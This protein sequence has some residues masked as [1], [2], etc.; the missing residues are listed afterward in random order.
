MFS[1][2]SINEF[3]EKFKT[4]QDCLKYILDKKLA[5]GY[6]CLKCQGNQYGKGRKWNYLRCKKCG[7]DASAT[8]GTLFHKCKLG[9]LKAFEMAFRVSVRKKGMSSCELSKEFGCQQRSAWLWKAKIQEAMKSSG[10]HPLSGAV[11]V[12]EFLLGGFSEGE[13]GRTH[14]SKDLVVLA[15]EK[16]KDKKGKITIGRA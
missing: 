16:V 5:G 1:G 9:L 3:R 11:E 10:K 14:G 12:D 4:E 2:I 8:A 6:S 15:I 7:Y 13:R